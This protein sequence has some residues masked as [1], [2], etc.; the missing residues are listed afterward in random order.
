MRMI[1]PWILIG[2]GLFSAAGALFDWEWFMNARRTRSVSRVLGRTG[3]RVFYGL[4]GL[5]LAV[6]GVLG[7]VGI[8][9][10]GR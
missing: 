1:L 9:D 8:I 5:A 2:G 6:G 7:L 4:L 3:A 10:F